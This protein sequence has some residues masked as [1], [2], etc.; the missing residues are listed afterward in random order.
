MTAKRH[1]VTTVGFISLGCPKDVVD[2]EKIL[3]EIAQGAFFMTNK[4]DN[5]DV[6]IINTCGFIEPAK[7]EALDAIRH[8]VDSKN[9]GCVRKVIVAGC[10]SQRL[11]RQLF[12]QVE[13]IDAIVGLGQRDNIA[14]II[15]RT[16]SAGRPA[17]YLGH[18][19]EKCSDD[20]ERLLITGRLWAYL[21]ISE[22]CNHRCSFCTIPAIRDP[23]T[24]ANHGN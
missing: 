1:K 2:S 23:F 8:A 14:R 21:R 22:G 18:L 9:K 13:G 3:A 20:R 17:A 4:S 12:N 11:G 5:A 7:I 24:E 19:P 15:E 10:L 16:I 6:I